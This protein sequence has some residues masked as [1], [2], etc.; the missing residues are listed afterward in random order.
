MAKD[1]LDEFRAA[2][3]GLDNLFSNF[4]SIQHQDNFPLHNIYR[5][6]TNKFK[7]EFALAGYSKS[8]ISISV[9]ENLLTIQSASYPSNLFRGT[10]RDE[11][12]N[13]LDKEGNIILTIYHG[14]TEKPFEKCFQLGD[15]IIVNNAE[16]KEGILT[17]DL[18]QQVPEE[19]KT[20]T[21]TIK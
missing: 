15:H 18:E 14:I 9:K 21:I 19:K 8:D 6:G 12:F 16:F 2:S 10:E 1:I 11:Q 4:F 20:K 17:I 7:L 3:V 13:K 5:I